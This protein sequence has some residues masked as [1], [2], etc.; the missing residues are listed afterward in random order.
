MKENRNKSN[1]VESESFEQ[2]RG[3]LAQL[4]MSQ[5]DLSLLSGFSLSAVNKWACGRAKTPR[6]IIEHLELL[7][8]F[9]E[10]EEKVIN[11]MKELKKSGKA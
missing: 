3:L 6:I 4:K 2:L 11:A 7:T 5:A 1:H 8:T 9:G 10:M